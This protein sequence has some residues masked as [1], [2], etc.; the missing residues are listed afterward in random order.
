MINSN[1]TH[2]DIKLYFHTAM[3]KTII[4]DNILYYKNFRRFNGM[5]YNLH[6]NNLITN[7]LLQSVIY[8]T[9]R[10]SVRHKPFK[11]Y[12]MPVK[13]VTYVEAKNQTERQ[14]R[15][16]RSGKCRLLP[17]G[18]FELNGD[19]LLFLVLAYNKKIAR[20]QKSHR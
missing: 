18:K 10:L 3:H 4:N 12:V 9:I 7:D 16:D 2:H 5:I 17:S 15:V 1:N 11:H 8:T 19:V 20:R 13:S 14:N 6:K